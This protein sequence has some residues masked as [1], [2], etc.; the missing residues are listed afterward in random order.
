M[1]SLNLVYLIK[2]SENMNLLN[3]N[4]LYE[5]RRVSDN[6]RIILVLVLIAFTVNMAIPQPVSAEYGLWPN[7]NEVE[8]VMKNA[9]PMDLLTARFIAYEQK[10]EQLKEQK[11]MRV[12]T[13][14]ATAYS[15][16]IDQTD[17]TPCITASGFDVCQHGEEDIMAANFLP[18]GAKVRIP[19]LYDDK[20]FT[21]EDR[22]NPR[23]S[24]R[25]DLWK[26][27]RERALGFGKRLVKLE[28]V[29]Y[30]SKYNIAM[31]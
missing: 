30:T 27:T 2:F 12:V 3:N 19:E 4:L 23:Y 18:L 31:K 20:V 15:S 6:I 13:V 28:I 21:V 8:L 11:P 9:E 22:M 24:H 1:N 7:Y 16:T 10:Q 26:T 14:V 25:I 5:F 29:E 17:S